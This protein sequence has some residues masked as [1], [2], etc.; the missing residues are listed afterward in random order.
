MA[1]GTGALMRSGAILPDELLTRVFEILDEGATHRHELQDN[2]EFD[3]DTYTHT[4]RLSPRYL[5]MHA[6]RVCRHWSRLARKIIYTDVSLPDVSSFVLFKRTLQENSSLGLWTS[7]LAIHWLTRP[8]TPQ[9]QEE[10]ER[11]RAGAKAQ[12]QLYSM[13]PYLRTL[14]LCSGFSNDFSVCGLPS[15]SVA[16][17]SPNLAELCLHSFY[18]DGAALSNVPETLRRLTLEDCHI[19]RVDQA[20]CLPHLQSFEYLMA[21]CCYR[22]S[23]VLAEN[24]FANLLA[25]TELS[26][27]LDL[28]NSDTARKA[29]MNVLPRITKLRIQTGTSRAHLSA[30]FKV[31]GT[32][33]RHLVIEG[34]VGRHGMLALPASLRSFT[35]RQEMT[36]DS[37]NLPFLLRQF[38]DGHLL[39][40][41]ESLPVIE[42]SSDYL[43]KNHEPNP[44][45]CS[46]IPEAYE[47]LRHVRKLPE[48][49]RFQRNKDLSIWKNVRKQV[50]E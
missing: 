29:L 43:K 22:G 7:T 12:I 21:S 3:K 13:L 23:S 11:E 38:I 5:A 2:R 10:Q 4:F 40:H 6:C 17:I 48:S 1:N 9:N 49:T 8:P 41:L 19:A 25:L 32:Y 26:V 45:K 14:C 31:M 42:V 28:V 30:Y 18:I 35:W 46:A 33:L 16:A 34:N 37:Y 20:L 39:P 24:S 15:G 44:F 27:D 36:A 47:Y 50:S